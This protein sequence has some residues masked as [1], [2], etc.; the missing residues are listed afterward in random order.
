MDNAEFA[1]CMEGMRHGDQEALRKVYDAYA[2][3]IYHVILRIVVQREDAQDIASEFFLKLFR[4]A[5]RFEYGRGHK[6]WLTV[7]ARNMALDFIRA[8]K[9]EIPSGAWDE[10]PGQDQV[11]AD[12]PGYEQALQEI[13]IKQ[14]LAVLTPQERE[15]VHY[16]IM[17]D[18]T[19]REISEILELPQGT[20]A[21]RYRQALKKLRRYGYEA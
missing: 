12:E 17:G 5:D 19:L 2:V 3:Y 6:A 7:M 11:S 13:T 9:K 10:L 15:I 4:Q 1:L 21:S 16:K 20:V 8:N 18:L 14:E